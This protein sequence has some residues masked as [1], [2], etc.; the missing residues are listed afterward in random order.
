LTIG[1]G[2]KEG[3]A[4]KMVL[5]AFEEFVPLSEK[6]KLHLAVENV[7]GM[8][9]HDF[10]TTRFLIDYFNSPY[11][12]VNY[13]PSHDILAGNLDI[14]WIIRQWGK[15]NIK[16]IHL[17]DAAGIQT[18]GQFVFPLPGEGFVDWK[19]FIAAVDDIGYEGVMS[20]EFESFEYLKK[21]LGNDMEK[22]ARISYENFCIL[23]G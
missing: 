8:L 19:S 22:A 4:W 10:Y 1:N 16:H 6:N 7:W 11:L 17:K 5:D 9:C 23:F 2:I 3:E 15:D 14:G 21:I 18:Q 20:V 13:D 12:G